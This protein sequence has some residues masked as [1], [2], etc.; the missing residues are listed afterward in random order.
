VSP[1]RKALAEAI[2]ARD[3]AGAELRALTQARER[4]RQDAFRARRAVEDAERALT[5]ARDEARLALTAAYVDGEGDAAHDAIASAEASLALKQRRAAE[6]AIVE[7]E[8]NTRTSP[9][10]GH[11]FPSK[12]VDAAVR[13][14]V[15]ASA[16]V[17]RLVED[18]RTAEATFR[19]YHS[20]LRWL[21]SLECIPADLTEAAPKAHDTYYAPPDPRWVETLAE[22]TRNADAPLPE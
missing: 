8:L 19:T 3:E 14:V 22:L 1:E 7:E 16:V 17:R 4:A 18:F 12:R 5:Q 13:D 2:A 9:A 21:A 15:K 6:L 11:S 20:T 10:P